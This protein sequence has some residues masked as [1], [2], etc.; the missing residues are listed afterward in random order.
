MASSADSML[1]KN[2]R[3]SSMN[4]IGG[5]IMPIRDFTKEKVGKLKPLY[6]DESKPRGAGHN[7]YWICQ[8]ECGNLIS[9]SS[10]NLQSALRKGSNKSCGKCNAQVK[11]LTGQKFGKLTVVKHD[12]SHKA[13]SS[14]GWKHKWICKCECG[15]EISVFGANLTRLHTT[16]CGCLNGSIGEKNIEKLLKQSDI[17]FKKEY[18]F[19]DLKDKKKL[20]FDFAIFDKNNNLIELIE[21]DGRQ[22]S[23]EYTPWGQNSTLE[24]RIEH[25]KMKNDY[26]LRNQIKLI[27]IPYEMRDKITLKLLGLESYDK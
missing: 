22:H 23:N 6:I 12:D 25:D 21:F 18:S 8:C 3:K 13:D 7:I 2:A 11:D 26:C 27:R 16:S 10:C 5:K 15:N 9:V 19:E 4:I 17:R 24:E 14:N 1:Y 20:R